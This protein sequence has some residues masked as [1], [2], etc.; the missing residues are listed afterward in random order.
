[1]KQFCIS[2]GCHR[3]NIYAFSGKVTIVIDCLKHKICSRNN[4]FDSITSSVWHKT[5]TVSNAGVFSL[6]NQVTKSTNR[7]ILKQNISPDPIRYDLW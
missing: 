2:F 5:L 3:N 1:M 4:L 7:V 6:L